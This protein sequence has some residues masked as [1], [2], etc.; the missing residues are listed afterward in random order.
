MPRLP[1]ERGHRVIGPAKQ[2]VGAGP[3]AI[4]P[5]FAT[6]VTPGLQI[7]VLEQRLEPGPRS[8]SPAGLH[9]QVAQPGDRDSHVELPLED[10][11]AVLPTDRGP[12]LDGTYGPLVLPA[13]ACM[14]SERERRLLLVIGGRGS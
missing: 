6:P 4:A 10:R 14:H 9:Q 11:L 1:L 8:L 12:V 5:D 2:H 7:E 13:G 3:R